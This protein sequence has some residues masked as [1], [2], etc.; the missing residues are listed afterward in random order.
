[1]ATQAPACTIK[2]CETSSCAT[3]HCCKKDLCLDHLK[4]HK[5]QLNAQLVPL[6]NQINTF[7]DGLEHCTPASSSSFKELEQWRIEAHKT[8]D[9]FHE[10]MCYELFEERKNK[11]ME[12]LTTIRNTLDALIRKQGAT[13][14]NIDSL[15]NDMQLIEQ[16]INGLKN[17][18]V[19]L[20]PLVI[21]ANLVFQS[22]LSNR[23]LQRTEN[24]EL[25]QT[26]SGG[27]NDTRAFLNR[28]PFQL[29]IQLPSAKTILLTIDPTDTIITL[30]QRIA[31]RVGI[32]AEHQCLTKMGKILKDEYSIAIYDVQKQS[33]IS[34]S[35]RMNQQPTNDNT[36]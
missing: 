24:N 16:E 6:A 8:V 35:L 36:F 34:L 30:K 33:N 4:E 18:Q 9:Q 28:S 27:S 15:V 5:D 1:M 22:N 19:N 14:E 23:I 21:D 29:F 13:R 31:E 25:L 32:P 12:K 20:R 10:R 7:L 17:I 26:V 3:C 2:K 11:P